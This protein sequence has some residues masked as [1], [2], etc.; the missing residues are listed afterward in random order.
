[1]SLLHSSRSSC[2]SGC[3]RTEHTGWADPPRRPSSLLYL[4]WMGRQTLRAVG[5]RPDQGSLI[6]QQLYQTNNQTPRWLLEEIWELG[7]RHSKARSHLG[8]KAEPQSPSASEACPGGD[9]L[10]ASRVL[11]PPSQPPSESGPVPLGAAPR[12]G[13]SRAERHRDAASFL[14]PF[15]GFWP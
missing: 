11:S 12:C 10:L 8:G 7:P 3:G 2:T 4:P 14:W 5:L 15:S 9:A 6:L 13:P 1:M